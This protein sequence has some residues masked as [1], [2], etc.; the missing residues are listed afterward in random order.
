MSANPSTGPRTVSLVTGAEMPLLGL[1]TWQLRGDAAREAVLAALDAG[2]R[3]LDTATMYGNE[4]EIG[5]ALRESGLPREEIFLTTKLPP[6]QAGRERQT[7][8]AS[9]AALGLDAVDL[10]LIHWPPGGAGVPV[11]R[12]FL[13]LQAEGR[14][15][16]VGVSNYSPAQIDELVRETGVAPAV[17]Q[18]EWSPFLFDEA[19]LA[20]SRAQGVVLE[21]YSPFKSARL[22]SPVL[23]EI[24]ARHGKTPAQVIV[25][26]HVEHEVVVIPKSARRE[27]IVANADVWDFSL[28]ADD[29]AALDA[30]GRS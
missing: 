1:G 12:A 19:R 4:R 26:W 7:L 3:H 13:D 2:Y 25:R 9:L 30:L 15:R 5:E 8:E 22:D 16:A 6:Q 10:W 14:T 11:W 18:I 17:N 27:R 23:V 29:V 21:G 28:S 20:H 24:A